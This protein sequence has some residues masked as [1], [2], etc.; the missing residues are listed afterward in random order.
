MQK[1]EVACTSKMLVA[2]CQTTC[3]HIP[4][5]CSVNECSTTNDSAPLEKQLS[6]N[7]N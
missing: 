5:H 3:N 4:K 2:I 6:A 7:L 1:M